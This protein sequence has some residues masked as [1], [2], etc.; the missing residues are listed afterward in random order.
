MS[1]LAKGISIR[2]N[3]S[4]YDSQIAARA[5]GPEGI[6]F[7]DSHRVS[8]GDFLRILW[9]GNVRSLKRWQHAHVFDPFW[10]IYHNFTEGAYI[11]HEGNRINLTPECIV[12]VPANVLYET[13]LDVRM[14]NHLF[15]H[16]MVDPL[17]VLPISQ[18]MV[19]PLSPVS[20]ALTETLAQDLRRKDASQSLH[21]TLSLLHYLFA[22]LASVAGM[23]EQREGIAR[24]LREVEARPAS[25][26]NAGQ[27]AAFAGMSLRNFHRHFHQ[28]IGKTPAHFLNE[29]RLRE[30]ARRL[31]MTNLT[32]DEIADDL[33]FANRF[34]FSRLFRVFMGQPPAAFRK[35][36]QS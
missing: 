7:T 28:A 35:E 5:K 27:M 30:A 4:Y 3:M 14:V 18:P 21:H 33:G 17:A 32:I 15:V 20:R 1:G 25:L 2:A 8:G 31:A 23:P 13:F 16:F 10:R 29:T 36:R 11:K 19:L 24:V 26:S 6:G 12:M 22:P 9:A 34:H